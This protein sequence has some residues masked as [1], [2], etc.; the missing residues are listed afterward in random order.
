MQ[1][2]NLMEKLSGKMI[3]D[4]WKL[5][6]SKFSIVNYKTQNV[7]YCVECTVLQDAQTFL[8][9]AEI[10]TLSDKRYIVNIKTIKED[11]NWF[12]KA[13]KTKIKI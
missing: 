9:K 4:F 6:N 2:K 7:K 1:P 8:S 11:S 3:T 10:W 13:L 5:L 12:S